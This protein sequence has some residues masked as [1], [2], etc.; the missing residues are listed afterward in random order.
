MN[1]YEFKGR[2]TGLR[3]NHEFRYLIIANTFDEA[4]HIFHD[5]YHVEESFK[6]VVRSIVV[7]GEVA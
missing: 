2:T 6:R 7:I 4:I 1:I 5:K 3:E